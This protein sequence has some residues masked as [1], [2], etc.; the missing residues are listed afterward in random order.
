MICGSCIEITDF[1]IRE[2]KKGK[3]LSAKFLFDVAG[4]SADAVAVPVRLAEDQSLARLLLRHWR[5]E[6]GNAIV[7]DATNETAPTAE[8]AAVSVE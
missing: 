4:L 2:A 6:D 8:K 3:Y 7:E 5:L 1:V